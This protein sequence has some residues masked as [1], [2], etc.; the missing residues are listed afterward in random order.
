MDTFSVT[1]T[2]NVM[3]E[4]PNFAVV[5]LIQGADATKKC[6]VTLQ[7]FTKQDLNKIEEGENGD[8]DWT[9]QSDAKEE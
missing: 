8:D 3:T 1:D 6:T 4:D 7:I 5:S 2:G 9:S